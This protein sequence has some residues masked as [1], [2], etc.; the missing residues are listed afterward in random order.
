MRTPL[1]APVIM[2][3]SQPARHDGEESPSQVGR[4]SA[5]AV[6]VVIPLLNE[7]EVLPELVAS[8]DELRRATDAVVTAVLVDDASTD[9]TAGFLSGLRA[10][11]I[12]SLRCPGRLGQHRAVLAGMAEALRA[13]G[14]TAVATMDADM[15]PPPQALA[16]LL[17]YLGPFDLVVGGRTLR[18]RTAVRS[19]VSWALGY[20][21]RMLR[22]SPITDHGSMFR[23]MDRSV[24][25]R[26]VQMERLGACLSALTLLAATR[27]IQVAVPPSR[28]PRRSRYGAR[29][30]ARV[31]GDSIRVVLR[32]RLGRG[33]TAG[34][35]PC[36]G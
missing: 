32:T 12:T 30:I 1:P 24:A 5:G 6:A 18:E 28:S 14:V 23:L 8:L 21:C 2:T 29:G 34:P 26:C 27:P 20:M 22:A 36:V 4:A 13:T 10:G 15:D 3:A 11:W 17:P 16:V 35:T 7:E 31:A 9:G 33:P 25:A 19:L